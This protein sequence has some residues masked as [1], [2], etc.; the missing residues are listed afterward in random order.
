MAGVEGGKEGAVCTEGV[1][2]LSAEIGQGQ[3]VRG[4]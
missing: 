3:L 4:A 1:V 2:A